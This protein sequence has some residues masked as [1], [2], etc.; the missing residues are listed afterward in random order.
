MVVNLPA[1]FSQGAK[2]MRKAVVMDPV[3]D[4][5]I[6]MRGT[7]ADHSLRTIQLLV[8]SELVGSE[9]F[10]GGLATF[11]PGSRVALHAHPDAEEVNV[12]IGGEGKF[13]TDE[14]ERQLKTG[15][16]QFIPKG[17]NHA[18][19]NTG[20]GPLTILW[21]YSPPSLTAPK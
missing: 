14:G 5:W 19:E 15:D 7:A 6:E 20:D 4:G 3:T 21:L 13:I 16:W 12:V 1:I 18:H 11:D 2:A 17:R 9:Q 10:V 8:N